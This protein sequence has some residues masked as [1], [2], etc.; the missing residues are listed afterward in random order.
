MP[1]VASFVTQKENFFYENWEQ[2]WQSTK[3]NKIRYIKDHTSS[4]NGSRD[5]FRQDQVVLST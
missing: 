5:L 1:T 2:Q 4:W 3:N